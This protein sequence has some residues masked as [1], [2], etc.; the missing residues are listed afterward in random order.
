M[1]HC[2]S[3]VSE[4]AF[5]AP[6]HVKRRWLR[7]A[8]S[9]KPSH[10]DVTKSTS[11]ASAAPA[12]PDT[13]ATISP[14]ARPAYTSQQQR[15]SIQRSVSGFEKKSTRPQVAQKGKGDPPRI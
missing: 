6:Q 4:E 3:A 13:F 10:S 14:P 2:A 9:P 8:S 1:A 7:R 5:A 11:S 12:R 15:W